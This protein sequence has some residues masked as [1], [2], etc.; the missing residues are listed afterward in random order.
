[1]GSILGPA[2]G[3]WIAEHW[4]LRSVLFVATGINLL[5]T[6]ATMLLSEHPTPAVPGAAPRPGPGR[7]LSDRPFLWQMLVLALIIFSF[8]L[9]TLLTPSFLQDVK[10]LSVGQIGQMGTVASLGLMAFMLGVGQMRPERRLPFI[11][12]QLSVA[13]GLAL[14]LAAPSQ[15]SSLAFYPV[16]GLGYFCRGAVEAIWPVS[17]GRVALW[18]APQALS[19]GFAVMDTASQ[20]ARTLAPFAAGLLYARGPAWPLAAGLASLSLTLLLTLT[21]P[22]GRPR[23]LVEAPA[24]GT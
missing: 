3:G 11:L 1:V 15:A 10:G 8:D 23:P 4:G 2:L 6:G 20:L 7:V 14:L 19:L 16:L 22:Q 17:R 9:G 13:A 5:S 12:L 24:A 18:V 21:L